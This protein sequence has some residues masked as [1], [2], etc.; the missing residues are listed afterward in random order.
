LFLR[1]GAGV[2]TENL[3]GLTPLHLAA[4]NGHTETAALFIKEGADVNRQDMCEMT[5]LD[6]A[7]RE[8][9]AA[10]I[11]AEIERREALQAGKPVPPA[12]AFAASA[13]APHAE[14]ATGPVSKK[15]PNKPPSAPM[16]RWQ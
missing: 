5:P 6:W 12:T 8:G 9:T 16:Q 14:G 2:N 15:Q 4:L 7:S 11:S 1:K 3:F 10:L 13:S